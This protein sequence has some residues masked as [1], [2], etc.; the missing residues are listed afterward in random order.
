MVSLRWPDGSF[1]HSQKFRDAPTGN[2]F[3][4]RSRSLV[5]Y[6]FRCAIVCQRTSRTGLSA[7]VNL[8]LAMLSR[9]RGAVPTSALD[10]GPGTQDADLRWSKHRHIYRSVGAP[11][12]MGVHTRAMGPR[13]CIRLE[14]SGPSRT[15]KCCDSRCTDSSRT[16]QPDPHRSS[17]SNDGHISISA[18]SGILRTVGSGVACTRTSIHSRVIGEK[19]DTKPGNR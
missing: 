16:T 7:L 13:A 10:R 19:I 1:W 14:Y 11:D 9:R 3:H 5:S 15:A 12:R 4:Y 2:R 8:R 17:Q 18:H 6:L